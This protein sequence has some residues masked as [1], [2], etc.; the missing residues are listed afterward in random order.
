MPAIFPALFP[1][2]NAPLLFPQ[3]SVENVSF[4]GA[5]KGRSPLGRAG[6]PSRAHWLRTGAQP[7]GAPLEWHFYRAFPSKRLLKRAHNY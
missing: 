7:R 6:A 1:A 4:S 3:G 5:A 2:I